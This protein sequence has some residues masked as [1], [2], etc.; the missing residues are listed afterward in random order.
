M[1]IFGGCNKSDVITSVTVKNNSSEMPFE[2]CVGEMDFSKYYL[3]VEYSSGKVDEVNITLDMINSNDELKFYKVGL[4]EITVNYKKQVIKMYLDVN[5]KQLT[6]IYLEDMNV[7]Y[8]GEYYEVNVE[9]NLPKDVVV[10]YPNG[11]KFRDAGVYEIEALIFEEGFEV[12]HLTSTLVINKATYD[13]S[14]IE[15]NDATYV[16][17]GKTKAITVSGTLPEGVTVSYE[18]SKLAKDAGVYEVTAKFH[19]DYDNYEIIPDMKAAITINQAKYNID[20]IRL[21]DAVFVYDGT[22]HSLE[23]INEH[24]LPDGVLANFE[25]NS[26]VDVGVYEVSIYFNGDIKNYEEID[27]LKAVL[28]ITKASYDLSNVHFESALFKY[29]GTPKAIESSGELPSG[30][31]VNYFIYSTNLEISYDEFPTEVGTYVV[32]ARFS[33]N[34]DNYLEIEDMHAM[35]VIES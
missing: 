10:I 11:N 32:V 14:D 1:F 21:E 17:D 20:G 30:V 26:H 12:M 24:L 13:L 22:P 33:H 6:D 2:I 31:T 19:G 27:K 8:T 15:F 28:T 34:N 25:N 3:I 23:L 4:Q 29:D 7:Y 9:G 18:Y 5:E 35:I 16:Y